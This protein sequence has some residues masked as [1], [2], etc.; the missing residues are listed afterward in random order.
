MNIKRILLTAGLLVLATVSI[1]FADTESV[2][3][4]DV[5]NETQQ[6][7]YNAVLDNIYHK[8]E[9][10]VMVNY[11]LTEDELKDVME[12]VIADNPGCYWYTSSYKYIRK[13]SRVY[14]VTAYG[15]KDIN[16][17][18]LYTQALQELI[19]DIKPEDGYDT[20]IWKIYWKLRYNISFNGSDI[21][22]GQSSYKALVEHN[23]V[24]AGY[25]K[26]FKECCA[27]VGIESYYIRGNAGAEHAWNMCVSPDGM[28]HFYDITFDDTHDDMLHYNM[29]FDQLEKD[30]TT[31]NLSKQLIKKVTETAL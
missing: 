31:N 10:P 18:T 3:Y 17:P 15:Y 12:S 21:D 7:I 20:K 26:A 22:G 28:L 19:E 9:T 13:Y 5:L 2:K 30:R 23:A 27:A 1:C 24:C 14:S 16:D 4:Y 6:R 8:S 11:E 25:A 29:S